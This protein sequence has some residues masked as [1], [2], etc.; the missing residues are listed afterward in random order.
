MKLAH[1]DVILFLD[2]DD[3]WHPE[4]LLELSQNET[5]RSGQVV[6]FN[7]TVTKERRT[8]AGP[9][10]I[11][12]L[13]LKTR[14]MLNQ[15]VYIKNQVHMSCFAFPVSVLQGL[16]FDPH[17]RAYEDWEFLLSVCNRQM[18]THI[19]ILGSRVYEVDDETTDRRGNSQEASDINAILD[20]LYVYRRHPVTQELREQRAALLA[21][22]GFPVPSAFI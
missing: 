7:C 10:G 16:H 14:G 4:L 8:P 11:T 15:K 18:P 17:M 1:G 6:Y 5:L 12:E 21:S 19:D 2:D 22:V 9:I 3:A 13:E 20:Y